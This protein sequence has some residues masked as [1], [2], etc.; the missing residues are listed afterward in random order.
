MIVCLEFPPKIFFF[1]ET[2][3]KLDRK[4]AGLNKFC[5]TDDE[6]IMITETCP[7]GFRL[8]Q[9]N[10]LGPDSTPQICMFEN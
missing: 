6:L 4:N 10:M 9:G 8:F 5:C 1:H 3:F 7:G 2:L